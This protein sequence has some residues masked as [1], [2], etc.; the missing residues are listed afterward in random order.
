MAFGEFPLHE[1]TALAA[2]PRAVATSHPVWG[3]VSPSLYTLG[4]Q[5]SSDPSSVLS[6]SVVVRG[7]HC[8][9]PRGCMPRS[10]PGVQPAPEHPCPAVPYQPGAAHVVTAPLAASLCSG[11]IAL[12]SRA[13]GSVG[14]GPSGVQRDLST[15]AVSLCPCSAVCQHDP[16]GTLPHGLPHQRQLRGWHPPTCLHPLGEHRGHG[17]DQP[18]HGGIVLRSTP[19]AD[20]SFRA[21]SH[22]SASRQHPPAPWTSSTRAL[23]SLGSICLLCRW[24][25]PLVWYRRRRGA[26]SS[27][28][29]WFCIG[30]H[31]P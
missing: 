23:A 1:G 20:V 24:P 10:E 11:S 26:S 7:P 21:I 15:P 25:H 29:T 30:P 19:A 31:P 9:M 6:W 2:C 8:L 27:S 22:P 28:H 17:A 5:G 4:C 3:R 18:H 12:G 16:P 14:S 13:G